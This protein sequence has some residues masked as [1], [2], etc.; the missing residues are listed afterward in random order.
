MIKKYRISQIA[1]L[2]LASA[3]D[4]H[5]QSIDINMSGRNPNEGTA[6]GFQP[7]T[8]GRVRQATAKFGIPDSADSVSITISCVPGMDGNAVR[9]NYWKQGVVNYGYKLLGDGAYVINKTDDETNDYTD[10]TEA[11]GIQ[12]EISGL[13]AG[14]HTLMCYHNFTDAWSVVPKLNVYVD[15]KLSEQGIQQTVRATKESDAA[16]SYTR[17]V[18]GSP[19]NPVVIQY[20][21][22]LEEG[23]AYNNTGVNINALVFDMSNPNTMALD[24]IPSHHNWHVAPEG[25]VVTLQW[26]PAAK[27]VKHHVMLGTA[28]GELTEYAVTTEST[29]A[30]KDLY[31]LN[32]YYWRIDEE[33]AEGKIYTGIEWQFKI[34]QK[35]FDG[36]EGYGQFA[37]GGRGGT[38]YHVTTLEDAKDPTPGMLRYGL[39]MMTG[40]RTIVFDVGGMIRLTSRLVISDQFVTVAGQTAPGNGITLCDRPF[41]AASDNIV[42]H[43]RLRPGGAADWDG[44]SPN[45][46]TSDG[47]GLTG[48]DN[49]I[50]DHC[51]V[52]WTI[53]ESFSSRNAKNI[54][55]QHNMLA[56]ALT[57]AGHATQ[58]DRHGYHVQHG[59]A[60]SIGGEVGSFHHNLLAHCQ[61]RNW[62]MAAGLDNAGNMQGKLD[63]F[64]NVCYN[65]YDRTTDGGSHYAQFVGN[66]YI[67]GPDTKLSNLFSLDFENGPAV[68]GKLNAYVHGNIRENKNGTQSTDK[69]NDTYRA[70]GSGLDFSPFFDAPF[71]D[72]KAVVDDAEDALKKVLSDVGCTQ[73]V[74]DNHDRRMIEETLTRT[75]SKIGWHSKLRGLVD[76]E[77]ESEG[78]DGLNMFEIQRENDYDAD[79]DGIPRWFERVVGTDESAPNNNADTDLDGWTQL[80]DYLEFAAKPHVVIATG[81]SVK[82]NVAD[83][84]KGFTNVPAYT[85]VCGPFIQGGYVDARVQASVAASELTLI[86]GSSAG[87]STVR[88]TVTDA[89]GSAMTRL[90]HVAVTGATDGIEHVQSADFQPVRYEVYTP[91]GKQVTTP[92]RGGAYILRAYDKDGQCKVMKALRK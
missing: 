26:T 3:L 53:D 59:Y 10:I 77:T 68:E 56:E 74:I 47:M 86:A 41:G 83:Y 65:W 66:Y 49:A 14:E 70:T 27:A 9:D 5:A 81:N 24:P 45:E 78:Y 15:G 48:A 63:M 4:I 1:F 33:D 89:D 2:C 34:N 43:L 62:S 12:L 36:A 13:P 42:R 60:A 58:Y 30:L 28:S 64:N 38:V 31:S 18:V 82:V 40:P 21:A 91:D 16:V 54:S 79:Q 20:I 8:F 46:N 7:W 92:V 19:A 35:A 6:I 50:I 61:G 73:P 51:S 80:E 37:T 11:G 90:L 76:R 71:W 17:F 44:V 84:F 23:V 69:L 32:T 75:T 39:T 88:M 57:Y 87:L 85:A 22:Q 67:Q 72:S 29:C 25:N 52:S 55:F